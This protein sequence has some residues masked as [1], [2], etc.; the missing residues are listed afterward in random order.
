MDLSATME[1]PDVRKRAKKL[2]QRQLR[3]RLEHGSRYSPESLP[4]AAAAARRKAAVDSIW[5]RLEEAGLVK[6]EVK[7]DE[8]VDLEDLEGDM[9]DVELHEDTVPGGA[10]TILAQQKRFRE[11]VERDGVWGIVGSYRA[12]PSGEW[13]EADSCWGMEGYDDYENNEIADDVK[14]ATL[15]ALVDLADLHERLAEAVEEWSE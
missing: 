10:R 3:E 14:W 15:E 5:E 9:F 2:I 11:R 1:R 7:P 13:I 8:H 4:G 6:L 12:E